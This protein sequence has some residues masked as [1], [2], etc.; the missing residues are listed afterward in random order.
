VNEPEDKTLEKTT[1]LVADDDDSLR[2][3]VEHT[4]AEEGYEVISATDGSEALKLLK[5]HLPDLVVADVKMPGLSG[6]DLLKHIKSLPAGPQVVLV[7]AYGSIKDAVD[8]MK[9]GAFEYVTK[10]FERDELKVV[11]ARAVEMSKLARENVELRGQLIERYAISNILGQSKPMKDLFET[12]AKVAGSDASVLIMGESGTGKELVARAIHYNS[13]RSKKPFRPV[14]CSSVPEHLMESELFGHVKGAFTG[15]VRAKRGEFELA[16]GGTIFFD[17]IGDLKTDLQ[18]K[19]L[20][21]LQER[22]IKPVGAEALRSV[23]VRVI[24]ATNRDLEE[25]LKEGAFREDLYYRLNVVPMELPPLRERRD[26]VELLARHFIAKYARPGRKI[27][28]SPNALARLREY[29]WPGN[30]RELENAIER[31]IVL[32][33]NDTIGVEDLPKAVLEAKEPADRFLAHF[34]SEGVSLDELEG[35]LLRHALEKSGWN[36]TVAA[37]L[38]GISRPTLLYRMQK[39]DIAKEGDETGKGTATGKDR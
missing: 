36:Q 26:D 33:G 28:I 22:E 8:A 16:D 30:V 4:L 37:R 15:A 20:R 19:L 14:N 29:N 5:E 31:A 32:L 18:V 34:P 25:A 9:M 17:E 35:K 2:M 12:I 39:H 24:A 11:V 13:H 6:I 3:V 27:D 38:L 21:A 7:T 1:V 10:P 23:D